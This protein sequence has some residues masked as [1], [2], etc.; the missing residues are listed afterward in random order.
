M[1]STRKRC[2]FFIIK[3]DHFRSD[4][5]E[6]MDEKVA[7]LN[8]FVLL[9][10]KLLQPLQI[11]IRNITWPTFELEVFENNAYDIPFRSLVRRRIATYPLA[12]GLMSRLYSRKADWG[13]SNNKSWLIQS[14]EL[15]I[16][17]QWVGILSH[18]DY[19][20]L[21]LRVSPYDQSRNTSSK[22][23]MFTVDEL[24]SKYPRNQ[25]VIISDINAMHYTKNCLG[26]RSKGLIF[27]A[28]KNRSFLDDM[29]VA[30]NSKIFYQVLG[31]GMSWVAACSEVPYQ[32]TQQVN[33]PQ[34]MYSRAKFFAWQT[35]EQIFV[36]QKY[37][38]SELLSISMFDS[39]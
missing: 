36:E 33:F 8:N 3:G 11:D 38:P 15:P 18:G 37:A 7:K 21:C 6:S 32:V 35:G 25:V 23:I 9:I 5:P 1:L 27:S 2:D 16:P 4:W 31:G 29:A 24:L 34:R 28:T 10:G 17:D 12:P 14:T 19:V 30:I 26:D 20:S 13:T 39:V 22:Q